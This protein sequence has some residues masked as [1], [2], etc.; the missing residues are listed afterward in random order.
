MRKANG[1]R[2]TYSCGSTADDTI[3]FAGHSF[4]EWNYPRLVGRRLG[5]FFAPD[6]YRRRTKGPQVLGAHFALTRTAQN[7]RVHRRKDGVMQKVRSDVDT[8]RAVEPSRFCCVADEISHQIDLGLVRSLKVGG[9]SLRQSVAI[10]RQSYR[11]W[12]G[13]CCQFVKP[14]DICLHPGNGIANCFASS[15]QTWHDFLRQDGL[16]Y[17]NEQVV[18]AREEVVEGPDRHARAVHDI[19]NSELDAA[20]FLHQL[21]SGSNK[22]VAAFLRT[23]S[24]SLKGSL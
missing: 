9:A 6:A 20:V 12:A 5:G 19:L 13:I 14:L 21:N 24:R 23:H 15:T 3:R 10:G 16:V 7:S 4:P 11:C 18:L 17:G 22:A 2:K 1:D 8:E